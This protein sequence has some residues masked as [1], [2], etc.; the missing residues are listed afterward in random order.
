[1]FHYV[2]ALSL[3]YEYYWINPTIKSALLNGS[4]C[5]LNHLFSQTF[6]EVKLT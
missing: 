3:V 5:L 1:M 2:P 4:L 6:I